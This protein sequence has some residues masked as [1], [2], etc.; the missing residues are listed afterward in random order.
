MEPGTLRLPIN[1]FNNSVFIHDRYYDKDTT[2][3]IALIRLP[4]NVTYTN[5][6]RAVALPKGEQVYP[7]LHREPVVASGWG[8]DRDNGQATVFLNFVDL[9]T[10]KNTD[11]VLHYQPG[12]VKPNNICVSTAGGRGTCGGDSGGPLV[13]KN[14]NTLIG[15]TSFG[16]A[17]SCIKGTPVAFTRVQAYLD[18]I[19]FKTGIRL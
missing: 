8:K 18:W 2:N 9:L 3:D 15:I 4:Y 1:M 13:S 12:I 11:C 6:I 16:A 17:N 10:I 19:Q 7:L 5:Y 14:S